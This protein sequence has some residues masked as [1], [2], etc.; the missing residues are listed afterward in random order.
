M[1]TGLWARAMSP[2]RRARLSRAIR[3]RH[4]IDMCMRL[5]HLTPPVTASA[6]RLGALLLEFRGEALRFAD[7]LHLDRD[8]I[9]RVLQLLEAAAR[10][11][12][13]CVLSGCPR[14]D[15]PRPERAEDQQNGVN[16]G[17][18]LFTHREG[19][20]SSARVE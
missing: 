16:A 8:G 20:S 13:C 19:V 11:Q 1:P 3:P 15:P 14:R 18:G 12:G 10:G 2:A 9:D 6:V 4:A 17:M 5:S 7:A